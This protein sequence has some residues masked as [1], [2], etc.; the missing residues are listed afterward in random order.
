MIALLLSLTAVDAYVVPAIAQPRLLHSRISEVH[1][2][3]KVETL[4]AAPAGAPKA[5]SGDIVIAHYT[6]WLKTKIGTKGKQFDTSRGFL[7]QPFKF[8][9]GRNRVIKAWDVGI[10]KMKI[11]ETAR[12]TATSDLCYGKEGAG[13]IPANA[14]LVFEV[15]LIGVDGYQKSAFEK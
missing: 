2:G 14:D 8:A 9:L 11:G 13:P 5:K 12:L 1:M 3:V 10:A 15:E 6:G 4:K 7:K